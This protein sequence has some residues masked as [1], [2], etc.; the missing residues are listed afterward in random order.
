MKKI[1]VNTTV[2]LFSLCICLTGFEIML[3]AFSNTPLLRVHHHKLFCEHDPLLGWRKIANAK[4]T[5]RTSEYSVTESMNSRGIRG[6]EYSYVKLD[7]EYRILVLGDSFA[8]GYS[9]EFDNLFSEILKRKL[10]L[11]GSGCY[12]VINAGVG[13]YS[14]DQEFLFFQS[15]GKKYNPNLTILLFYDNDAWYNT[16]SKYGRGHKPLFKIT[17]GKLEMANFPV[18]FVNKEFKSGKKLIEIIKEWLQEKSY[19]YNFI[20]YR[21]KNSRWM[22]ALA[23][24][25]GL[26]QNANALI[27]YS[28]DK[29]NNVPSEYNVYN[30]EYSDELTRMWGITEALIF[31]LKTEALSVGSKL[32]IFYVPSRAAVYCD[33]WYAI[34]RRYDLSDTAWDV[35]QVALELESICNKHHI[36]FI[37][38]LN[39]F[40]AEAG[41]LK[42]KNERL[43]FFLDGH[44]NI[45]GHRLVADLLRSYIKEK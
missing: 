15:E 11:E 45:H 27:G 31:A 44:W 35:E 17:E 26:A 2:F 22:Y 42:K 9:V 5:H 16:K 30:K 41:K 7:S 29:I 33:E 43:Y 4:Y 39:S 19:L 32:L 14:T 20:V 28:I 23:M 3:R 1:V 21:I 8:E 24:K 34:K 40:R 37:N 36:D 18:P 10:N 25:L 13:G 12:Q 38:P 6:P